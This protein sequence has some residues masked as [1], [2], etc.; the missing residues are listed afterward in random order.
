MPGTNCDKFC[1]TLGL[2]ATLLSVSRNSGVKVFTLEY[3]ID[4]INVFTLEYDGDVCVRAKDTVATK[5]WPGCHTD[6]NW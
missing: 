1:S 3:K 4:S 6:G 2:E 5:Q